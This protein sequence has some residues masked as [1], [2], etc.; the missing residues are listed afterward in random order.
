MGRNIKR[1]RSQELVAD[2]ECSTLPKSR[3]GN[4]QSC[5]PAQAQDLQ[6]LIKV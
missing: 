1:I 6:N 3:K 4:L 5:G 2:G